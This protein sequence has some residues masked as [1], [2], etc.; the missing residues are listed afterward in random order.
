ML[1]SEEQTI[2]SLGLIDPLIV[3]VPK[4]HNTLGVVLNDDKALE[5]CLVERNA[6]LGFV[7]VAL[8]VLPLD[9]VVVIVLGQHNRPTLWVGLLFCYPLW[10]CWVYVLALKRVHRLLSTAPCYHKICYPKS[11]S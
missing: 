5:A 11:S 2:I 10:G 6:C 1:V 8:G 3:S 7:Y 4:G 9:N